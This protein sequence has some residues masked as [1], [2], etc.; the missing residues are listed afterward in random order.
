MTYYQ[1]IRG[2][3]MSFGDGSAE[4]ARQFEGNTLIK[5]CQ[6]G[7]DWTLPELCIM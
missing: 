7:H 1:M 2:M 6:E 3:S 4:G 5:L